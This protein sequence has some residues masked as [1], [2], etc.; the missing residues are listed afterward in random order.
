MRRMP[1][2]AL[3]ACLAAG[4]LI[5]PASG[6]N[7][8]DAKVVFVGT[9]QSTNSATFAEVP[10]SAR[11][12]IV[13]VDA[14][15]TKPKELSLLRAGQNVTVELREGAEA[16]AGTRARFFT[17][18]WISG[19]DGELALRELGREPVGTQELTPA[20]PAA[21]RAVADRQLLARATRASVVVV[22]RVLSVSNLPAAASALTD[23]S[24]AF[25]EHDPQWKQASIRVTSAVKGAT[26]NQT[27][28]V[29]FPS[30]NDVAW[31]DAPK[32]RVG[33]TGTFVFDAP[34]DAAFT[35][36]SVLT[37][38]SKDQVLPADAGQRM[39]QLLL[40]AR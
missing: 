34:Q 32:F 10:K 37:V 14:V 22:G 6:Q 7:L 12:A 29:R 40:N 35:A 33:Q 21:A 26:A 1:I 15:I 8:T 23:G 3:A 19:G 31:K 27:M 17:V 24:P 9:I 28:T 5:V 38:Q 16:Q 30:S 18:S 25:R 20:G 13:R 11:T 39:R 36:G 4:W 2:A